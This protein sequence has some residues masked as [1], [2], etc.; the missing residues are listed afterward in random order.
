MKQ[1]SEAYFIVLVEEGDTPERVASWIEDNSV[2][3]G[4]T[5]GESPYKKGD[6]QYD[7]WLIDPKPGDVIIFN[8]PYPIALIRYPGPVRK[9]PEL[10][11]TDAMAEMT[12]AWTDGDK[13]PFYGLGDVPGGVSGKV[14]EDEHVGSPSWYGDMDE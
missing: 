11:G 1:L 13:K 10:A 9:I 14:K 2:R 7:Q 5:D 12:K 3:E 4:Y 8:A 6:V